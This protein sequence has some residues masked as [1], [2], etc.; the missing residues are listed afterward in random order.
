MVTPPP[1]TVEDHPLMRQRILTWTPMQE[2]QPAIAMIEGASTVIFKAPTPFAAHKAA[3]KWR[4]EECE[5]AMRASAAVRARV[6]AAAKKRR[7][8]EGAGK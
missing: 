3:D 1:V 6:E 8:R 2:G 5:R 7:E 4:R